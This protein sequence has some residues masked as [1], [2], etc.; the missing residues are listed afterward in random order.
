MDYVRITQVI[1][2]LK[3]IAKL[4]LLLCVKSL[5]NNRSFVLPRMRESVNIWDFTERLFSSKQNLIIHNLKKKFIKW[6]ITLNY[7][8]LLLDYGYIHSYKI[9]WNLVGYLR[10][11][12]L[13]SWRWGT[14]LDCEMPP[15]ANTPDLPLWFVAQP[16]NP[17]F[18]A[19]LTWSDRRDSSNPSWIT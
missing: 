3:A 10:V 7:L 12:L 4:K 11:I 2:K 8:P 9:R 1:S 13:K 17:R 6:K 18:L 5:F 19:Y 14:S 16:R 15:S